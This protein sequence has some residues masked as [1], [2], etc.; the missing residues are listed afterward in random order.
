[1][2]HTLK[3]SLIHFSSNLNNQNYTVPWHFR[4]QMN[5]IQHCMAESLKA[6]LKFWKQNHFNVAMLTSKGHD[7]VEEV[8]LA[9]CSERPTIPTGQKGLACAVLLWLTDRLVNLCFPHVLSRRCRGS[10]KATP[11]PRS[12]ARIVEG[13]PGQGGQAGRARLEGRAAGSHT[14]P[15]RGQLSESCRFPQ[16]PLTFPHARTRAE[17]DLPGRR[18]A[19]Q[20]ADRYL[21]TMT[22]PHPRRPCPPPTAANH[23]QPPL[24]AATTGG[25]RPAPGDH[26]RGAS[27]PT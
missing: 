16:I 20:C 13:R 14:S 17:P 24:T 26:P 25:P 1:M 22:P 15:F 3:R 21:R 10:S 23:R 27:A 19:A 6:T 12:V 2:Y 18:S 5:D 4:K 9:A 11:A 8:D 7:G